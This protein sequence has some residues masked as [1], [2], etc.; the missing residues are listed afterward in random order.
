MNPWTQDS[1]PPKSK[2]G[3]IT[4]LSNQDRLDPR[5]SSVSQTGPRDPLSD[6]MDQSIENI[7]TCSRGSVKRRGWVK[8][9]ESFS[10]GENVSTGGDNK[11]KS[12][13]E[14][15]PPAACHKEHR[16]S[17]QVDDNEKIVA[18]VHEYP[19]EIMADEE[20]WWTDDELD[21]LLTEAMLVADQFTRTRQDW[22]DRI[23]AMLK[24]CKQTDGQKKPLKASDLEF[25]VDSDARGLELYIH[26]VFQKS[27]EKNIKSVVTLQKQI[28]VREAEKGPDPEFRL[29]AIKNKSMKLTQAARLMAKT[30]A[31]GDAR[32]AAKQDDSC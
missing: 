19:F 17:F 23:V 31:A 4:A 9:H 32:V 21:Q 14:E 13:R 18:V 8:G 12:Q 25:V 10:E 26:P 1:Q 2:P 11:H 3:D 28:A 20:V 29:N 30:L 24:H 6:I 22:Q 15:D 5:P 7:N 16:V 27:R